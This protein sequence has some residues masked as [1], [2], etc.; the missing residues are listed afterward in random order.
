VR[1]PLGAMVGLGVWTLT[2]YVAHRWVMHGSFA[3]RNPLGAE[4]RAHHV[5]PAAT[6]APARGAG[7]TALGILAGGL[8]GVSGGG[9]LAVGG[10]VGWFAGYAAYEQFH[11]REHHRA[12]L[13]PWERRARE[14]HA[15]H[16]STCP[17][18]T[19]RPP[20]S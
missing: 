3:R 6:S 8:A 15:L 19:V 9:P 4:H 10:A 11:W 12:P 2:E 14:R 7:Y 16:H 13:G 1:G 20:G 17:R 18:A 5:D